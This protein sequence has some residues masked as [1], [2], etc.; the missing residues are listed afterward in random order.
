MNDIRTRLCDILTKNIGSVKK[1]VF[2]KATDKSII[3]SQARPILLKDQPHFVLESFTSDNKALHQNLPFDKAP[4]YFT[5]LALNE[6]KQTNIITAGGECSVLVSKKGRVSLID[7]IKDGSQITPLAE[8]NRSKNYIIDSTEHTAFLHALGVCD[9]KGNVFDKK[10]AKY[11]Q[12]NRFVELLGDVYSHL[13]E[14]TDKTLTVCDLCCGKSY[15]TFAVYYYLT[16]LKN[17]RVRMY[18][19]DLKADVIEYCTQTAKRLGCDGLEFV[20]ADIMTFKTENPPDLVVSLHA[21]DVATDVVLAYAVKNKAR[22]I[23]STPCCHHE[24]FHNMHSSELGFLEKHSILK[25]KL[26]DAA[27]DALRALRLEAEGYNVEAIELIDP[28][29]T[30]KNVMIRAFRS[31]KIAPGKRQKALDEYSKACQMLGVQPTLD[32]LL[33]E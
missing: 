11:K 7:K 19:V 9:E 14:D 20:C 16:K 17:R 21:C 31:D 15:L 30:P 5:H 24:M 6:Y 28:E 13:P 1:I 8:H 3:R 32:K 2:S 27:T 29:E 10:R 22:L 25:Q 33:R 26:C 23:L 18:G 12:I 4:E